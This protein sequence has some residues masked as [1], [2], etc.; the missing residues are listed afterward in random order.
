[1]IPKQIGKT[2]EINNCFLLL[3]SVNRLIHFYFIFIRVWLNAGMTYLLGKGG[4]WGDLQPL[5]KAL[6][7]QTTRLKYK[8]PSIEVQGRRRAHLSRPCYLFRALLAVADGVLRG[9]APCF[10]TEAVHHGVE[11]AILGV[12]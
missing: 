11:V 6:I 4:W 12:K 3:P 9:V 5:K 1:M 10:L 7:S 2:L 8:H